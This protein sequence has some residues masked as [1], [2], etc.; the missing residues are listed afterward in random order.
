MHTI[1]VELH[2][3]E[4]VDESNGFIARGEI[5]LPRVPQV[6]DKLDLKSFCLPIEQI[7]WQPFSDVKVQI[8]VA[9]R[10]ED[11]HCPSTVDEFL[12]KLEAELTELQWEIS[13][14]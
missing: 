5:E 4:A 2:V 11:H 8:E 1:Q 14:A 7:V 6:G 13:E 9:F 3:F 10:V 12:D